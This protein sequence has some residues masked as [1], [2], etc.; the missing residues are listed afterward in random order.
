M[1]GPKCKM[2]GPKWKMQDQT[3]PH[4]AAKLIAPHP[5]FPLIAPHVLVCRAFCRR[6]DRAYRPTTQDLI[7][8]TI[9]KHY[10]ILKLNQKTPRVK[11]PHGREGDI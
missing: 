8:I 4:T 10:K 9:T 5:L 7:T 1:Q 2:Q 11:L 3:N 6:H